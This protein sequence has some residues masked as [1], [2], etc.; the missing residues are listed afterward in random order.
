MLVTRADALTKY[1]PFKFALV[2][3][4]DKLCSNISCMAWK[5]DKVVPTT[6][7]EMGYCGIAGEPSPEDRR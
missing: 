4:P 2:A 1:C 7:E 5:K 6:H 3:E